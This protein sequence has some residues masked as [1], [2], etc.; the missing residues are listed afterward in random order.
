[1]WGSSKEP[2]RSW[3]VPRNASRGPEFQ[4]QGAIVN[5]HVKS[6]IGRIIRSVVTVITTLVIRRT[7]LLHLGT[8]VFSPQQQKSFG[9]SSQFRP[10]YNVHSYSKL[11]ILDLH[12][13]VLLT[14]YPL[15]Q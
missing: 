14:T 1:M 8:S 5:T 9:S 3:L 4:G 2:I 7:Y 13:L 12:Q 6:R 15:S 11:A 10:P